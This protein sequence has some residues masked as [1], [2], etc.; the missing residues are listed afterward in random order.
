MIK[1]YGKIAL[2]L[3]VVSL[4]G[5]AL[6]HFGFSFIGFCVLALIIAFSYPVMVDPLPKDEVDQLYYALAIVGL[7]LFFTFDRSDAVFVTTRQLHES[8]MRVARL[9]QFRDEPAAALAE[10]ELKEFLIAQINSST[11]PEAVQLVLTVGRTRLEYGSMPT[12]SVADYYSAVSS[13]EQKERAIQIFSAAAHAALKTEEAWEKAKA[14]ELAA[15][16]LERA[17]SWD[18]FRLATL[19]PFLLC[20]ALA[21]KIARVRLKF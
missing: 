2:F 1:N 13:K 8:Q 14:A 3:L 15:A 10:R 16:N 4:L 19:W 17:A 9:K 11:R 7:A 18:R 5:T 6:V 21:L 12:S 20:L